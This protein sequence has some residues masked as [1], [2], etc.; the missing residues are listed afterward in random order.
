MILPSTKIVCC[1]SAYSESKGQTKMATPAKDPSG[2]PWA[3]K[4]GECQTVQPGRSERNS[5]KI[6]SASPCN[7]CKQI[8]CFPLARI[9]R[10]SKEAAREPAWQTAIPWQF[11]TMVARDPKS[12]KGRGVWLGPRLPSCFCLK[13]SESGLN[14]GIIQIDGHTFLMLP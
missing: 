14:N 3:S 1:T 9:L 13:I 8:T 6:S 10:W 5:A 12:P 2:S 7:S 11:Q 4:V